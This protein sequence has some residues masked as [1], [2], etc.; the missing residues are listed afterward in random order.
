MHTSMSEPSE[1]DNDLRIFVHLRILCGGS[2]RPLFIGVRGIF[3]QG[4]K[5]SKV[6]DWYGLKRVKL[7]FTPH[8]FA[9]ISIQILFCGQ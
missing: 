1:G 8:I 6:V 9:Q 5:S 4:G 2:A 3:L 7:L